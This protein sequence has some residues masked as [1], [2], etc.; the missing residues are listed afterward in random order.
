MSVVEVRKFTFE[1]VFDERGRVIRGPGRDQE[2]YDADEVDAARQAA[3][4]E[5]ERSA[6]AKAEEAAAQA[7][8]QIAAAAA[9]LAARLG[10]M[11]A[12]LKRDAAAMGLAAARA[13]CSEALA[14]YPDEEPA[15][16][17]EE[18]AELLRDRPRVIVRLAPGAAEG[19]RARIEAA[20]ARAGCAE[21][22]AIE[23]DESA[24]PGA[25]VIEWPDGAV[26]RSAEIALARVEEAARRWLADEGA[27]TGAQLDL[28]G[29]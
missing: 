1:T 28:F 8:Q 16:F 18:C 3:F 10:E 9:E 4:A 12:A 7:A 14:R 2:Y 27:E 13:A 25:C 23:I 15:S 6:V 17:F 21:G 26:E 24:Q 11:S 5:G 29:G 22:L 20:A 19:A